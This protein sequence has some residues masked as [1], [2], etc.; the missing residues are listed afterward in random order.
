MPR[1]ESRHSSTL[2][3]LPRFIRTMNLDSFKG[4][5][6]PRRLA[7][8]AYSL[9]KRLEELHAQGLTVAAFSAASVW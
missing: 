7:R 1:T 6:S 3:T 9:L 5:L 2:L 8:T 4:T